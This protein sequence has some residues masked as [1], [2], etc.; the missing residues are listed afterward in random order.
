MK[1]ALAQIAPKLSRENFDIHESVIKEVENIA[2]VVVFPELSLNGYML[3]DAIYEDAFLLSELTLFEELSE[4]IDVIVGAVTKE[5]HKI[6]NSALYYS[7]GQLINVHHKV[8]LSNYGMSQ[9]A[10]FFFKGEAVKSFMTPLGKTMVVI[11]EDLWDTTVLDAI[12]CEK[13]AFVYVIASSPARDFD[14]AGLEIEKRWEQ[15]L[16]TTAMLSGAHLFFTNRVGFEDGM[17]FWGG[18]KVIDAS[19]RIQK[20]ARLF[21]KEVLLSACDCQLSYVQKYLLRSN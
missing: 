16:S 13:P 2:D 17:G 21:D 6:Y 18:S 10:R 9:E 8:N 14:E 4:N 15:I 5:E 7:R 3:M 20:S 11:C 19:G 1:V 12:T